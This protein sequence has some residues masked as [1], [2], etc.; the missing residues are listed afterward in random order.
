MKS[1]IIYGPNASSKSNILKVLRYMQFVVLYSNSP[2][3]GII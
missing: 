2:T 3:F 1:A